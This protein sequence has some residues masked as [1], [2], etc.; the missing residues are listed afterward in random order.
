MYESTYLFIEYKHKPVCGGIVT[1]TDERF[2]QG[3]SILLS[4]SR[5]AINTVE[6]FVFQLGSINEI[7]I[8]ILLKLSP[9]DTGHCHIFF[10]S[11]E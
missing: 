4:D 3:E 1:S 8:D 6:S 11:S 10:H 5:S 9:G 2:V 7:G